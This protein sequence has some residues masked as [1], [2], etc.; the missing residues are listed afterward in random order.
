MN[1]K[2]IE[3]DNGNCR[4]YYRDGR[5]LR[6]FQEDTRDRFTLYICSADGEPECEAKPAEL[7]I[8]GLPDDDTATAVSFRRWWEA[9]APKHFAVF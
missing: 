6:C 5:K 2:F 9:K 4:V 1:L 8:D 3:T 7:Q